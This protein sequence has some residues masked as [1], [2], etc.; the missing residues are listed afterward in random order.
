MNDQDWRKAFEADYE[1]FDSDAQDAASGW[2]CCAVG[3]RL[4][5]EKKDF[6]LNDGSMKKLLT[7]KAYRLGLK[8]NDH[9][10][11]YNVK[12]AEKVYNQIQKL[13]SL[14]RVKGKTYHFW[15]A[16]F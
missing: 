2:G 16:Y 8:F 9:V 11:N 14:I 6:P 10:S 3:C 7:P 5:K 1:F 15:D 12:K 4:Q 13:D